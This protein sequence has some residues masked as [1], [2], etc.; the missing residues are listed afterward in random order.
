MNMEFVF[1]G[2][3]FWDTPIRRHHHFVNGISGNGHKSIFLD[4][5]VSIVDKRFKSQLTKGVRVI[6]DNLVI[7]SPV[8][9]LPFGRFG[10]VKAINGSSFRSQILRILGKKKTKRRVLFIWD[11]WEADK[12]IGKIGEDL[13]V[14]D[15]Y[16]NYMAYEDEEFYRKKALD[17]IRW[18]IDKSDLIL[19][20]SSRQY[21]FACSFKNKELVRLIRNG[22]DIDNYMK[23]DDKISVFDDGNPVVAYLGG[24]NFETCPK[25]DWDLVD[26]ITD[27]NSVNFLFIGPVG[28]KKVDNPLLKKVMVKSNV[29]FTGKIPAKDIPPLL[30]G[31]KVGILPWKIT[32]FTDW[33]YPLKVNEYLASGLAIVSTPLSDLKKMACKLP[34][35][36]FVADGKKEFLSRIKELAYMEYERSMVDR[37]K[38]FAMRNSWDSRIS[39]VLAMVEDALVN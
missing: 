6:S 22:V 18:V 2:Y 34:E 14:F 31:A 28:E 24:N 12:Y 17:K 15:I 20:S 38:N 3:E 9:W 5:S 30:K 32:E 19:T 7:Y 25:M 27:D 35:D 29:K 10:L 37:R 36:V 26:F 23:S 16:D 33:V 11:F 8:A 21:D 1:I 39:D 13:V 4:P